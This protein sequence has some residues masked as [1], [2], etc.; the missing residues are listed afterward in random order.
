MHEV[1]AEGVAG[2]TREDRPMRLRSEIPDLK[3][4]QKMNK[5]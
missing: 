1:V 4:E 2:E 3:I 5:N